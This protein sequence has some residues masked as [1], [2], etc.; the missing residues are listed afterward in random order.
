M[1]APRPSNLRGTV[2]WLP[3][4]AFPFAYIFAKVTF[5]KYR[6]SKSQATAAVKGADK[7]TL[8]RLLSTFTIF[9]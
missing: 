2:F 4:L 3:M 7:L 8:T 1:S 5:K 9:K 6:L